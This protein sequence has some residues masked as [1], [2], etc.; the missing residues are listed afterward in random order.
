MTEVIDPERRK[1]KREFLLIVAIALLI[2]AVT[3]LEIHLPRLRY[4]LPLG[5]NILFFSIININV[6]LLLLLIFLVVRNLVKKSQLK[7]DI[8][9]LFRS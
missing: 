4:Q 2:A 1:R 6:V 5:G 3:Y 8:L 7:A 9:D